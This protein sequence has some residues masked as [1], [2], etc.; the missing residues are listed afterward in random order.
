MGP[1]R[2][3][4]RIAVQQSKWRPISNAVFFCFQHGIDD[5]S[6]D[7]AVCC[8]FVLVI[9]LFCFNVFDLTIL[10]LFGV[11]S[12]AAWFYCVCFVAVMSADCNIFTLF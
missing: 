11:R 9:L 7:P 4:M 2:E 5:Q 6:F 1:H 3:C 8:C 10:S 12:V